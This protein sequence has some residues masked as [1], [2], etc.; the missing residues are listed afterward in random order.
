MVPTWE[1]KFE[2]TSNFQTRRNWE[3]IVH[4][5]S[6]KT[7]NKLR[8]AAWMIA[9]LPVIFLRDL[10]SMSEEPKELHYILELF[11]NDN[12]WLGPQNN[13]FTDNFAIAVCKLPWRNI[14]NAWHYNISYQINAELATKI[15]W[16]NYYWIKSTIQITNNQI[17]GIFL[18]I[19]RH[20]VQR[21]FLCWATCDISI[22]DS[23]F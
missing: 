17:S 23:I 16:S 3:K 1:E 10:N 13:Y 7:V 14:F 8:A 11:F 5:Y 22:E 4:F 21:M 18:P 12:M 15:Q 2:S 6:G 20:P 9:S 19:C